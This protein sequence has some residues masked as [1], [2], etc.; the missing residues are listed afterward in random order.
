MDCHCHNDQ[1]GSFVVLFARVPYHP[2]SLNPPDPFIQ[3]VSSFSEKSTDL[4]PV[5]NI[6]A[7]EGLVEEMSS[8]K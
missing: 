7:W 1:D 5:V 8:F 2:P 6:W 3:F 4:L